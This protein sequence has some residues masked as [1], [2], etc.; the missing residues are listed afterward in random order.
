MESSV[1]APHIEV[2][3]P[4]R[5]A[6]GTREITFVQALNEAMHGEMARDP[7]VFVM[8][9]DVGLIGGVFGATRGLR[10][11]FGG[12]RVRDTPISGP[13]LGGLGGGAAGGGLPPP[14]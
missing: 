4:A 13:A 12:E 14:R 10:E 11:A 7:R 5:P 1:Y 9:E 3:E 6:A 8:G 2:S